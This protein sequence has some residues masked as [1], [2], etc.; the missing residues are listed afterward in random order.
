MNTR[1]LQAI[2]AAI[3]CTLSPIAAKLLKNVPQDGIGNLLISVDDAH[4]D[5]DYNTQRIMVLFDLNCLGDINMN[6]PDFQLYFG[7]DNNPNQ[8]LMIN[9]IINNHYPCLSHNSDLNFQHYRTGHGISF[10]DINDDNSNCIHDK[11]IQLNYN[12]HCIDMFSYEPLFRLNSVE[13]FGKGY[14]K[15]GTGN[16]TCLTQST[17]S[18]SLPNAGAWDL[19]QLDSLVGDDKY[20]FP[21][22]DSS[23]CFEWSTSCLLVFFLLLFFCLCC[24]ISLH[25]ILCVYW[26]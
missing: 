25:N 1:L 5:N 17:D 10:L 12:D 19:D 9:S 20:T 14:A 18:G 26:Q 22:I 4:N 11:N 8:T 24:S 16:Y 6:Q 13:N 23:V 15:K 3:C 21:N 7:H 2:F